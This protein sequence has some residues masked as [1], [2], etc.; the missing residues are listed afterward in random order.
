MQAVADS[1]SRGADVYT[2]R[3]IFPGDEDSLQGAA[4]LELDEK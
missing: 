1:V 2:Y 4:E 3:D